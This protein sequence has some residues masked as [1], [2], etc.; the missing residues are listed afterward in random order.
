MSTHDCSLKEKPVDMNDI[1]EKSVVVDNAPE[2]PAGANHIPEKSAR[3][4]T[5][6]EWIAEYWKGIKRGNDVPCCCPRKMTSADK[7]FSVF[8]KGSLMRSI[9]K[10][11]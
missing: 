11:N 1:S 6:S 10:N 4:M 8:G 5:S 7:K 3:E 2:K 9:Q